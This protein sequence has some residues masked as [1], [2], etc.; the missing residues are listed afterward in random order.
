MLTTS[1]LPCDMICAS[2]DKATVQSPQHHRSCH[3]FC[4]DCKGSGICE[5]QRLRTRCNDCKGS[6]IC[7]HQRRRTQCKDC[8][9]S[10]ICVHW[11]NKRICV[12]CA[13][14]DKD[15]VDDSEVEALVLIVYD[16]EEVEALVPILYHLLAGDMIFLNQCLRWVNI[17]P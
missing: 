14:G 5:H 8:T 16:V 6:G 2:A 4:K 12:H 10:G 15:L 17:V 13:N 7:E 1:Q 3:F 11:N 9:G